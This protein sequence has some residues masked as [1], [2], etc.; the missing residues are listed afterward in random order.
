MVD[1]TLSY[2]VA[3]SGT[4]GA[5]FCYGELCWAKMTNVIIMH[6]TAQYYGGG[7]FA[8][9]NSVIN[10]I[11]TKVTKNSPY[12]VYKTSAGDDD[13]IYM[14]VNCM[15]CANA[16]GQV[17]GPIKGKPAICGMI[18][19]VSVSPHSN[20]MPGSEMTISGTGILIGD[21][22]NITSVYLG[23]AG[24]LLEVSSL[25]FSFYVPYRGSV[26][27]APIVILTA[28]GGRA[29]TYES[30][31]FGISSE[32]D[33]ACN[34]IAVQ[35]PWPERVYIDTQVPI[36]YVL[37]SDCPYSPAITCVFGDMR[38]SAATNNSTAICLS[39]VLA[40]GRKVSL[41]LESSMPGHVHYLG[42]SSFEFSVNCGPFIPPDGYVVMHCDTHYFG[43]YCDLACAPGWTGVPVD[44]SCQA[45][46]TWSTTAGM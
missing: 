26:G 11:S 36:T 34:V 27:S 42:N 30:Y 17:F 3:A 40:H 4:G 46:G 37:R 8:T 1:S 16:D 31:N 38:V 14:D 5:L 23:N 2:N 33:S 10:M 35:G 28:N 32:A 44:P 45:D 6:N 12:G 13:N 41:L 29:E 25:P 43:T 20:T 18:T 22:D 15:V 24:V 19:Y 39:P 21:Q 7:V 9:D